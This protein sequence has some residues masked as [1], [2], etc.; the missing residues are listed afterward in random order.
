[1]RNSDMPIVYNAYASNPL[2]MVPRGILALL[3]Q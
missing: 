3:Q 1:M 2:S